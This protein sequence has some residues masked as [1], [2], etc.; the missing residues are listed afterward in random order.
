[1]RRPGLGHGIDLV[2]ERVLRLAEEIRKPLLLLHWFTFG[3]LGPNRPAN[4]P[5]RFLSCFR[6]KIAG[7]L[8]RE[9]GPGLDGSSV[10][11]RV[12]FFEKAVRAI[13]VLDAAARNRFCCIDSSEGAGGA[14]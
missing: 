1:M 9:V 14:V 7:R 11:S 8:V 6:R 5:W 13:I 10:A 3:L 12:S 4:D 2:V